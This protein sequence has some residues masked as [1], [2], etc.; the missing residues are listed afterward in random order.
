MVVVLLLSQTPT[1]DPDGW[2][3]M[4]QSTLRPVAATAL[5]C[6]PASTSATPIPPTRQA[7][8]A[9]QARQRMRWTRL[10]TISFRS[11]AIGRFQRAHV[12]DRPAISRSAYAQ[13]AAIG[14]ALKQ[15]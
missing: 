7:T 3:E 8:P 1:G 5:A 11:A 4:W 15:R 10:M 13:A 2:E 12:H 14:V 9:A 6:H